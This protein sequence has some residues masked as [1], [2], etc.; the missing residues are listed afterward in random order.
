[1]KGF[2]GEKKLT[3]LPYKV[4]NFLLGEG[5]GVLVKCEKRKVKSELWS[6][7]EKGRGQMTLKVCGGPEG[8][9]DTIWDVNFLENSIKVGLHGMWTDTQFI[10]D[11]VI[12][13][14]NGDHGEYFNLSFGEFFRDFL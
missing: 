4:L 14:P 12:G 2:E 8:C 10:S 3:F 1:M 6:M 7:V 11:L 13:C 5:S 9:L